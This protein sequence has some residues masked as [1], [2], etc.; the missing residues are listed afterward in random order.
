[1]KR[2]KKLVIASVICCAAGL[3]TLAGCG[4][5]GGSASTS[6]TVSGS[7]LTPG[8]TTTARVAGRNAPALAGAT[9]TVSVQEIVDNGSNTA[10]VSGETGDNGQFTLTVPNEYGMRAKRLIVA[11]SVRG[12][13]LR[14]HVT[15]SSNLQVSPVSEATYQLIDEKLTAEGK[16]YS[17]LSFTEVSNIATAVSSA[18]GTSFE[19]FGATSSISAAV[20]NAKNTAQFDS[21]VQA[22]LN[23]AVDESV[24][25]SITYLVMAN[26]PSGWS[27]TQGDFAYMEL[28]G[29]T[30]A[31]PVPVYNFLNPNPVKSDVSIRQD[32]TYVYVLNRYNYD[33]VVVLDPSNAFGVVSNYSIKENSTDSTYNPYDIEVISTTKAYITL[34]EKDYILVTNPSTGAK[35]GEISLAD[36]TVTTTNRTDGTEDSLPEAN[37]MVK[38]GDKVFVTLQ[39][40]DRVNVKSDGFSWT[41]PETGVVAVVDSTTD[42]LIDV[43]ASTAGTQG[44]DL[45]D[46]NC[47]RNPGVPVYYDGNIYL[48][49]QGSS[50]DPTSSEPAGIA[51]IDVST[52]QVTRLAA[53]GT[54]FDCSPGNIAVSSS[55]KGYF[56]C[57]STW[58]TSYV[59]SF[60]PTTGQVNTGSG[61]EVFSG[62]VGFDLAIDPYGN[63][64]VPSRSTTEPGLLFFDTDTD[65]QV[66][67]TAIDV[68]LMPEVLTFF[69]YTP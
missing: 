34:Y 61:E 22:N 50:F 5:G 9:A 15:S 49:C 8:G 33:T 48:S 32:G 39:N 40:L 23:A 65:R 13:T 53:K 60:N 42:S 24:P 59:Y 3:L 47:G 55:T 11:A 44:I 1:M 7:V 27:E 16:T 37:M 62:P 63:L 31:A 19:N 25:A 21:E 17:D 18:V 68:G 6:Y 36:L 20:S 12:T 10:I 58:P 30:S 14:A 28:S 66:F 57:L 46:T 54:D 29:S 45:T 51:K 64:V 41:I 26:T 2:M 38:V 56:N 67:S 52:Y 35:V 69:T 4:G 43:D